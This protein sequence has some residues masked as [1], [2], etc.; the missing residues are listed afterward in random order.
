MS[1]CV[2]VLFMV[3]KANSVAYWWWYYCF[4]HEMEHRAGT[5]SSHMGKI[6]LQ[7]FQWHLK[8]LS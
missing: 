5:Y 4:W 1:V 3:M 2:Y 6:A 8:S 7:S